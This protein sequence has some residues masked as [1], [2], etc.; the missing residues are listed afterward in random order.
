MMKPIAEVLKLFN[1]SFAL[2]SSLEV[3]N[4]A[5]VAVERLENMGSMGMAA[6]FG[7]T[8][9]QPEEIF[10]NYNEKWLEYYGQENLLNDDPTAVYGLTNVGI[11]HWEYLEEHAA[12]FGCS[13][14]VFQAARAFGME[15]GTTFALKVGERRTVASVSHR[16]S[17]NDLFRREIYSLLFDIT[18]DLYPDTYKSVNKGS[19]NMG[20]IDVLKLMARDHRD[21]EIADLLN[22][23]IQTIRARRRQIMGKLRAKTISGVI[24]KAKDAGYI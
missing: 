3:G 23:S 8:E 22:L 13:T 6:S 12:D 5:R 4:R 19:I 18:L 20:E 24:S 21:Q 9:S 15:S 14:R 1:S 11:V 7:F 2:S 17:V 16:K 10:S